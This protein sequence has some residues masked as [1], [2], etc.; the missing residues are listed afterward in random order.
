MV[1]KNKSKFLQEQLFPSVDVMG[2]HT[3]LMRHFLRAELRGK[4]LNSDMS[5]MLTFEVLSVAASSLAQTLAN[6]RGH[7][8]PE[9]D[10]FASENFMARMDPL[11]SSDDDQIGRAH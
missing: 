1:A 3:T 5:F 6:C 2:E 10:V 11:T 7:V 9:S 4:R 8:D